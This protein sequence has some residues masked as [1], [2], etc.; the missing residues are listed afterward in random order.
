MKLS[1]NRDLLPE[2]GP[3]PP[4]RLFSILVATTLGL[5][6]VALIVSA[7]YSLGVT[8]ASPDGV[9]AAVLVGAGGAFCWL[10]AVQALRTAV[11]GQ[12]VPLW[13]VRF[14]QRTAAL[15]LLVIAGYTFAYGHLV[16]GS[17]LVAV[18]VGWLLIPFVLRTRG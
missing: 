8:Y 18:A 15:Y 1:A 14:L 13:P 9:A 6:G 7:V 4:N 5:I 2:D 12:P 3:K 10:G 17:L 16:I 11:T